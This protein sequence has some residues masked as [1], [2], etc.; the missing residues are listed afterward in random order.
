MADALNNYIVNRGWDDFEAAMN[1]WKAHIAK[2]GRDSRDDFRVFTANER[3]KLGDSKPPPHVKVRDLRSKD[4]KPDQFLQR[5]KSTLSMY[6]VSTPVKLTTGQG[7]QFA[8]KLGSTTYKH[9]KLIHNPGQAVIDALFSFGGTV[10]PDASKMN[11]EGYPRYDDPGERSAAQGIYPDITALGVDAF[12]PRITHRMMQMD[13]T[14]EEMTRLQTISNHIN[15]GWIESNGTLSGVLGRIKAMCEVSQRAHRVGFS[16]VPVLAANMPYNETVVD[17]EPILRMGSFK[18]FDRKVQVTE[19]DDDGVEQTFMRVQEW[20]KQEIHFLRSLNVRSDVEAGFPYDPKTK[21]H[22]VRYFHMSFCAKMTKYLA[23]ATK[24]G[25]LGDLETAERAAVHFAELLQGLNVNRGKRKTEITT[26]VKFLTATRIIGVTPFAVTCGLQMLSKLVGGVHKPWEPNQE[27]LYGFNP[28]SGGVNRFIESL[29]NQNRNQYFYYSDNLYHY[30]HINGVFSSYDGSK[31]EA[32]HINEDQV[33]ST[34]QRLLKHVEFK[35]GANFDGNA[36]QAEWFKTFVRALIEE[37]G[38]KLTI[39]QPT[40]IAGCAFIQSGMGSGAAL[41]FEM[42]H[43][44]TADSLA[45]FKDSGVSIAHIV[46]WFSQNSPITLRKEMSCDDPKLAETKSNAV[47][48]GLQGYYDLAADVHPTMISTTVRPPTAAG[49]AHSKVVPLDLLGFDAVF[50]EQA[51]TYVGVLNGSRALTHYFLPPS[52]LEKVESAMVGSRLATIMS[53]FLIGGYA[54]KPILDYHNTYVHFLLETI[55]VS[56]LTEQAFVSADKVGDEDSVDLASL[57]AVCYVAAKAFK[58]ALNKK[59]TKKWTEVPDYMNA[60][61]GITFMMDKKMRPKYREYLKENKL[62]SLYGLYIQEKFDEDME[63]FN[64]PAA[65]LSRYKNAMFAGGYQLELG[66]MPVKVPR[67]D[68]SAAAPPVQEKAVLQETEDRASAY[69]IPAANAETP[70]IDLGPASPEDQGAKRRTRSASAKPKEGG[71]K[72]SGSQRPQQQANVR[73]E[74]NVVRF[75]PSKPVV[76]LGGE[77]RHVV[78]VEDGTDL[79]L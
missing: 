15:G 27:S 21:K 20:T 79:D 64:S 72:R 69:Q 58:N 36:E 51:N 76:E 24:D 35:L 12:I 62:L 16:K 26:L 63:K 56:N 7:G 49:R 3:I 2:G 45:A 78:S 5:M 55:N 40:V 48:E 8:A 25:D 10:D 17:L 53:V 43:A 44:L 37:M 9:A 60:H 75:A 42:N 19:L 54:H 32:S 14:G 61:D 33:R 57:T 68:Q 41:T 38:T 28:Y 13:A 18:E 50:V 4:I 1:H 23:T 34:L 71:R 73:D 39:N 6:S 77:L 30:D 74:A 59:S 29:V 11:W 70:G 52:K 31:M 46:D 47:Y 66:D 67:K 65:F 22:H